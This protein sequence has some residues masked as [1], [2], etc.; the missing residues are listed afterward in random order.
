MNFSLRKLSLLM[1]F[2]MALVISIVN[3]AMADDNDLDL[4]KD[5]VA[6]SRGVY[7]TPYPCL[8]DWLNNNEDFYHTHNIYLPTRRE[9]SVGPGW[10]FIL[11][12]SQS[13]L[14]ERV[15]AETKYDFQ[16]DEGSVY[17]VGTTNVYAIV[18]GW[19]K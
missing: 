17:I 2:I 4:N 19:F 3:L 8:T 13:S 12:E 7:T 5:I 11:F 14:L 9:V 15:T 16:N 6:T 1:I 10:D 18:K